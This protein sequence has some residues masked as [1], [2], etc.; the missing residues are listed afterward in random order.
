LVSALGTA[1]VG[2]PVNLDHLPAAALG[3]LAELA[4]LVLDCL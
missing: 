2:I 4:D 3:H 1:D